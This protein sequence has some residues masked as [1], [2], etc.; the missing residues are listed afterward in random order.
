MLIEEPEA[1]LDAAAQRRVAAALRDLPTYAIQTVVVSHSPVLIGATGPA[2]WR[3]VR[4]GLG[5]LRG[6]TRWLRHHV[7]A[8]DGLVEIARELDA[9]PSDVLLARRFVVVE[10]ESDVQAFDGWARRLGSPLE[11][12]GVRLVPAGGHGSAA[13]V[14]RVLDLVYPGADV[15]VVLDN[16]P[17]TQKSKLEIEAR[18]GVPVRLL[19]RTEIEAY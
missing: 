9:R 6:R 15:L 3:L 12:H 10:G 5:P 2:G 19:A 18:H 7:V 11:D 4:A 8:A 17:D 14:G 16:G 1:G 13:Q